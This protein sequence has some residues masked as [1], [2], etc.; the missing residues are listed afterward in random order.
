[1]GIRSQ[2]RDDASVWQELRRRRVTRVVVTYL[3][4]AFAVF[5]GAALVLTT[6]ALPAWTPRA[7]LGVLVLGFPLALVLAWTYD[8]TRDGIVR[9]PMEP[10]AGQESAPRTRSRWV[11]IGALGL[12]VLFR[13]LQG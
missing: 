1:M 11:A 10:R 9:T 6:P 2:R 3:A 5:E 4:V 8:I 7:V 12:G 13:V